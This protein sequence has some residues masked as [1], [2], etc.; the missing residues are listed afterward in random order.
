[1]KKKYSETKEK[2]ELWG[3]ISTLVIEESFDEFIKKCYAG[4]K[5]KWKQVVVS[6]RARSR[7]DYREA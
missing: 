6:K 7:I 3:F 4:V 5:D 2:D 1:V